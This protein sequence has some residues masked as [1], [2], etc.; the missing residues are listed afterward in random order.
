MIARHRPDL[1]LMDINL[2]GTDGLEFTRELKANPKTA[3]VVVI[4]LTAQPMPIFERVARAAGC[5]DYI[6]KPA[7]PAVLAAAVRDHLAE[8]GVGEE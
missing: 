7:S 2:P 3:G 4:A 1:I 5:S 6:R 8:A